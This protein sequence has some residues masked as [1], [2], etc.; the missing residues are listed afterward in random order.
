MNDSVI[1]VERFKG[2]AAKQAGE[3]TS[4]KPAIIAAPYAWR[5][6]STIPPRDW[7]YARHYIRG[8]V[9]ATIAPGGMGKS[10]LAFAE[11]V[12]MCTG[13]NLLG[14]P[15]REKLRVW[16]WNGEDPAV[17]LERRVAA[18]CLH[19]GIDHAELAGRLFLNSG[20]DMPIRLAE[21]AKGDVRINQAEIDGI[22]DQCLKRKIDALIIDPWVS[23][24]GLPESANTEIDR[25][26]KAG[27]SVIAE[28]ANISIDIVHHVRKPSS[29]QTEVTA[30]DARGASALL[31]AV[32]SARVLNLLTPNQ[33]T[34]AN[35]SEE[36][37]RRHFRV[38]FG[39]TSMV[40]PNSASKWHQLVS[41]PLGNATREMPEDHVGVVTPWTLPDAFAD[42]QVDD[43]RKVQAEIAKGEWA[44]NIQS[45]NWA[46]LAIGSVMQ[47]DSRTGQGKAKAKALLAAWL[48]SGALRIEMSH[49]KRNGRARPMVVPGVAV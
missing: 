32:R 43:I 41:V 21:M 9:T 39:K 48:K 19:Y 3:R 12:A 2:N 16:V 34:S 45:S 15:V 5:D 40:P 1:T 11:A 10:S 24:H 46:G 28:Q 42:V 29:G 6:P 17:E 44:E 47:F 26:I 7:L 49:D 4:S 33:A 18:I 36:D 22:R 25:V 13:R 8:F 31:S 20:R 38:D 30:D 27:V 35:I 14:H 23:A 37:R